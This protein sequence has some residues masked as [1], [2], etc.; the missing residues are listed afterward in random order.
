[1]DALKVEHSIFFTNMMTSSPNTTGDITADDGQNSNV[2]ILKRVESELKKVDALINGFGGYLTKS[3]KNDAEQLQKRLMKLKN[4]FND[5]M[6][7]L[8]EALSTFQHNAESLKTIRASGMRRQEMSQILEAKG[9]LYFGRDNRTLKDLLRGPKRNAEAPLNF[10][11]LCYKTT[12]SGDALEQFNLCLEYLYELAAQ[13]M[14][15]IF[16]DLELLLVDSF[17]DKLKQFLN[18]TGVPKAINSMDGFPH[19]G[20]R[21][22]K[23]RGADQLLTA[24]FVAAERR[25]FVCDDVLF[26]VF[27][28]CRPLMLG[29]KVA[30]ISD[31]FDRL[32]DAHFKLNEWS[33]GRLEIRSA[34]NGKGAEIVKINGDVERRLPIPQ[35]ALPAKVIGFEEIW[36]S[37]IDRSMIE[38][39]RRL[40][41]LFDDCK[42]TILFIGID[43]D[44]KRS[45][46]II[47]YRIWPLINDNIFGISLRSSELARLHQFY[48]FILD[49]CPKLR[50]IHSDYAFPAS[51]GTFSEQALAKW[52]HTPRGD[53]LAKMLRCKFRLNG[54]EGL[55]RAFVNSVVS[56]N[57]VICLNDCWDSVDIVPFKLKNYLT[58]E[59]LVFRH[60]KGD[61][62]LLI[63]CP[64]ERDEK[65]WA[66]WEMMA[67]G[68][69]K[70]WLRNRININFNDSFIGDGLFGAK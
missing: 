35:N 66:E 2:Q 13:Q 53:G 56:V 55:K 16:V 8:G 39:L 10:V 11:L 52:L 22:I 34:D 50:L 1:M 28:F 27:K 41:R 12:A 67:T 51:A 33:L 29:L 68:W 31:R 37:Y 59:R 44:Q 40:R 24:D 21:L 26:E 23:M 60:F 32:V 69:N 46:Q 65:Q 18:D 19:I 43:T 70:S 48:P 36:I 14:N 20:V 4:N 42:G 7:A 58:G 61:K 54:M 30:L 63:R 47:W 5:S 9:I 57:F 6:T 62:W 64:I 49:D 45:W 38:F 17:M 25:S 15:C 3:E